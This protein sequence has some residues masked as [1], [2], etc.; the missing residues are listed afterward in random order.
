MLQFED[1]NPVTNRPPYEDLE[2][3]IRELEEELIR[4]KRAERA[5]QESEERFRSLAE[6]TS[7]WIWEVDRNGCYTYTSPKIFD[8]L[9][10]DPT[11]VIGK[12][13]FDFMPLYEKEQIGRVFIGITESHRPFSHLENVNLHK[14]GREIVL[15]TSGVPVFD[16][17]GNYS[18]YRGID[19]DISQRKLAEKALRE[20]EERYRTLFDNANDAIFILKD[21]QFMECNAWALKIYG[22]TRE[23]IIGKTPYAL[24]PPL[25]PDGMDSKEKALGK[26]NKA[27][28]GEPQSFEW[29]HCR[30]DGTPFDA[31]VSLNCV[32]INN[33]IRLQAIVRDITERKQV[34]A[35]LR[36]S[37]GK[38]RFLAE[39]MTDIIW[40]VNMDLRVTFASPSI[41]EALGFTPEERYRQNLVE[42]VTPESYS[43]VIDIF[44]QELEKEKHG[45]V[46]PDRSLAVEMEY[47]HK[48]GYTVWM[49]NKLCA[50]RDRDDNLIGIHGVSRDITKRKR[51]EEALVE[52]E[53]KYRLLVENS[54][55]LIYSLDG[56][57]YFTFVNA[58]AERF[59]DMTRSEIVGK[60]YL[61]L[62][63]PDFREEVFAFYR[64]RYGSSSYL[65]YPIVTRSGEA[66][67]L[68]TNVQPL[69][70]DGKV[71]G[72]QAVAR[73]ITDRKR[74]EAEREKIISELQNAL[75]RIKTLSGL[76]PICA[77]CK[78]I[79]NDEGY[80][81]QIELY[82]RDRSEAEF[83][84]GIC[85]ECA[86]KLYPELKIYKD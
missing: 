45:N 58:A 46:D 48:D 19:R 21:D 44:A 64:K 12:K 61:A 74:V 15:E 53:E 32:K 27:A 16:K 30:Y 60:N 31:E 6:T 80:W 4:N 50:I 83:S 55:D 41:K 77:S 63:R 75:S 25:Q 5:L 71:A 66:R 51:T 23:Q 17:G 38:Y 76:L 54:N 42:T 34:E 13:P 7:D 65:E 72:F 14:D 39:K 1:C 26:I 43:E 11:E 10:Y 82:I 47:Y 84:H 69:L 35:A 49:E 29:R 37:E 68:G 85:P 73:D 70:S 24:S 62:I 56:K 78:K 57:G 8:L 40:T 20:S 67:W 28:T 2:R 18:G 33:E 59:L 9:G 81:E 3:R 86:I 52:S 22:C 79:R 36:E